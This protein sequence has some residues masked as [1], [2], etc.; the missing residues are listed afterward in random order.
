MNGC[1]RPDQPTQEGGDDHQEV[2]WHASLGT[3][4]IRPTCG[5]VIT[6][7]RGTGGT[8]QPWTS[9]LLTRATAKGSSPTSREGTLLTGCH[10][11]AGSGQTQVGAQSSPCAE[12]CLRFMSLSAIVHV[13]PYGWMPIQDSQWL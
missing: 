2:E 11:T 10:L 1:C 6:F 4:M 5:I 3:K 13:T 9:T 12:F 8:K 7:M